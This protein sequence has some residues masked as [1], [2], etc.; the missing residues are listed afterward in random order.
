MKF[1]SCKNAQNQP[2]FYST[3][4]SKVVVLVL[5]LLFFALWFILRGYL[6]YVLH[7]CY[8]V[9]VFFSPFSVA[10]TSLGEEGANLSAFCTFVRL[11]DL[12]LFGFVCF[13][14]WCLRR[15]AVCNCGTPW[16]F[17]LPFL[18]CDVKKT[19][20]MFVFKSIICLE[21]FDKVKFLKQSMIFVIVSL[22]IVP[23]TYG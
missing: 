19:F 7:L 13:L 3:D 21:M 22:L 12:R 17:L 9:L 8:F 6:F 23:E 4:R 14:F 20:N 16:T 1:A 15:A 10:S 18:V 2:V 11:F 5:V